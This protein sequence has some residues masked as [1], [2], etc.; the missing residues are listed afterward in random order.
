MTR[1]NDVKAG[2]A[3]PAPEI[4]VDHRTREQR[5]KMPPDARAK[6]EAVIARARTPEHGA[7]QERIREKYRALDRD[8]LASGAYQVW[9]RHGDLLDFLE[10]LGR[11][12]RQREQQGLSLDEMAA[13]TG[14][15]RMAI[16]RLENGKNLNP[17]IT[18][19][20]RYANALG[21][22]ISWALDHEGAA[23]AGQSPESTGKPVARE[24]RS[25]PI[26]SS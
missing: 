23:P 13:R 18:T 1:E 20:V 3:A 4:R 14:M 26:G 6:A 15:D 25:L 5:D 10:F 12:K 22:S 8:P 21:R 9:G 7:L 17:T 11:L 19:L 24:G 16:S 2:G